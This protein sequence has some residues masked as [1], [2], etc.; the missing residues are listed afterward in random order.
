RRS[1]PADATERE[2]GGA[3]P[4][5]IGR[6]RRA[7][8]APRA[9]AVHALLRDVHAERR[10]ADRGA[11]VSGPGGG[12]R[13]DRALPEA[14]LPTLQPDGLPRPD[15][16]LPALAHDRG[17]RRAGDPKGKPR[18]DR[19]RGNGRWDAHALGRRDGK[20]RRRIDVDRRAGPRDRLSSAR[21]RSRAVS[22]TRSWP[23][24]RS[25]LSRTKV[26][27]GRLRAPAVIAEE[28]HDL[29]GR[30]EGRS[31]VEAS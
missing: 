12:L 27:I 5:R 17:D 7:G 30:E 3:F 22:D 29:R 2:G 10:G 23:D 8:A 15:R 21:H 4:H 11:R 18:R 26:A 28:P 14:R 25:W 6:H 20:G 13:R 1:E 16:D 19:T 31:N 9:E 24:I